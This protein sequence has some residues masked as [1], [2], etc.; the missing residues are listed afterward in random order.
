MPES[1]IPDHL[2][3]SL[4]R[5]FW[6]VK[7]DEV[8][9]NTSSIYVIH[10]LLDKGNIGAARWV[11]RHFPREYIIETLEKMRDFTPRNGTFW[12]TYFGL[13][14]KEVACLNPSYLKQRRQLWPY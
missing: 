6:D 4:Y 12:A 1:S 14:E 5:Y 2:P 7:A 8:N 9:P 13:N 11:L 3:P 10:R